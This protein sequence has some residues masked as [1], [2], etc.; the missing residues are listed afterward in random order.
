MRTT[1]RTALIACIGALRV[2]WERVE[3]APDARLYPQAR[4]TLQAWGRRSSSTSSCDI[5]HAVSRDREGSETMRHATADRRRRELH[6]G[7]SRSHVRPFRNVRWQARLPYGHRTPRKEEKDGPR[8][9]FG[10]A[11]TAQLR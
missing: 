11:E 4:E 1:V 9:G 6:S 2:R 10:E 7:D 8:A 5:A 3:E